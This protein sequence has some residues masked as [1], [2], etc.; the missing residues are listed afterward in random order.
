YQAAL[1]VSHLLGDGLVERVG[2]VRV[3]RG[4]GTVGAPGFLALAADPA[5]PVTVLDL[6]ATG[7][8]QGVAAPLAFSALGVR[9]REAVAAAAGP[10]SDA[11]ARGDVEIPAAP[12]AHVVA[13]PRDGV[14]AAV[15][16]RAVAR[17]NVFTYA[18]AVL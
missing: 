15:T 10:A 9:A 16:D 12:T 7:R 14:V 1:I 3:V 17:L 2:R 6:A 13:G 8:G 11:V 18:G 5:L 4:G